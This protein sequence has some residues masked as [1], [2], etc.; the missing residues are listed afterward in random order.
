MIFFLGMQQ[1]CGRQIGPT[2]RQAMAIASVRVFSHT[3]LPPFPEFHLI[4][5]VQSAYYCDKYFTFI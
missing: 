2:I 1:K 4:V 5:H 3:M